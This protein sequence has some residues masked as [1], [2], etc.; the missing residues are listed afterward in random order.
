V[1][2]RP[3]GPLSPGN[4][5]GSGRSPGDNDHA[6]LAAVI[7]W[8]DAKPASPPALRA[9]MKDAIS[10]VRVA[11]SGLRPPEILAEASLVCLRAVLNAVPPKRAAAPDLLAAD[12]LL[13]YAC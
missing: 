2:R 4:A 10:Q 6:A 3:F 8:L 7:R 13:T 9:R 12:A 11:R 1:S 5:Q